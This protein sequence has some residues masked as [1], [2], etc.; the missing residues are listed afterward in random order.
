MSYYLRYRPRIESVGCDGGV[1]TLAGEMTMSQ[2]ITPEE[3]R[4]LTP[5]VTGAGRTVPVGEQL[6]RVHVIGPYGG[7]ISDVR[8]G[9]EQVAAPRRQA[10]L[11]G[12]PV[13]TLAVLLDSTDDVDVT[14][15]M[16]TGPGQTD[17]TVINVTPGVEP[18]SSQRQAP[19]T[20]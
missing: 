5:Y 11:E 18:G 1:Q 12:R 15:T 16:T 9:G 3:A 7:T 4:A 2:T 20:C 14:W 13:T 17:P 10:M 8:I 19:T 6:V